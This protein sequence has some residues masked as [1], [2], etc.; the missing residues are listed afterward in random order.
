[1]TFFSVD[2]VGPRMFAASL[3]FSGDLSSNQLCSQLA[4]VH[5]QFLLME[6]NVMPGQD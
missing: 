2:Q 1:M 4:G 6:E 5:L 3:S